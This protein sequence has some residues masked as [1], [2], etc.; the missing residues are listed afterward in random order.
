MNKFCSVENIR[1]SQ[2]V[3]LVAKLQKVEWRQ[4]DAWRYITM[5]AI[6]GLRRS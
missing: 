1:P 4:D 5:F 3:S 2:A 6:G